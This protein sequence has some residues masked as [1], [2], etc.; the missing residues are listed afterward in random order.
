MKNAKKVDK[1]SEQFEKYNKPF[2]TRFRELMDG[3]TQEKLAKGLNVR[4]QTI[5]NYCNGKA[6]PDFEMLVKIANYFNVSTDYLTGKTRIKSVDLTLQKVCEYTGLSERAMSKLT[7]KR[8]Y[9]GDEFRFI[10]KI[11][12]NDN[13]VDLLGLITSH[14][15]NKDVKH[16]KYDLESTKQISDLF[17]CSDSQISKYLEMSSQKAIEETF[18]K[19]VNDINYFG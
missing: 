19:I 1:Y 2:P 11:L 17:N 18:M 7:N 5:S 12:E 14:T 16:F 6:T 8:L 15:Y 3:M 4:R 10:N 9:R 13:F